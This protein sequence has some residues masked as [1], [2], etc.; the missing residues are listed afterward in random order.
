MLTA[1]IVVP[2]CIFPAWRCHALLI[3]GSLPETLFVNLLLL[4]SHFVMNDFSHLQI[5]T[6]HLNMPSFYKLD[7]MRMGN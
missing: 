1:C 4:K 5:K 7:F 2:L 6:D 3:P